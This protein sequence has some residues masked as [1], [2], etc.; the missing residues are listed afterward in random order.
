M[1][2]QTTTQTTIE[3]Q[4]H[5]ASSIHYAIARAPE[6]VRPRLQ[7]LYALHR[8]WREA[9][10]AADNHF[11]VTT[12]NWWHE[13]LQSHRAPSSSPS[14]HPALLVMQ[15]ILAQADCADALEQLLHGHM[16]WH[17][18]NRVDS[19]E[20]LL[21]TI[22]AIGGQFVRTWLALSEVQVAPDYATHAGRALWWIDQ[23]RH[24]GHQ[25]KNERIW[26]PMQWLKHTD[27]PAHLLL[28]RQQTPQQRVQQL[29][30]LIQHIHEHTLSEVAQYRAAHAQLSADERKQVRSLHLLMQLRVDLIQE[31][32][33]E[34][35][36]LFQG[37]VSLAPLR[38]WWRAVRS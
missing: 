22:D 15:P 12:L 14:G 27:V 7:A 1:M 24:L 4:A 33:S 8:K 28:N 32:M 30:K 19:L 36:A 26:I 38:K 37:L 2:N 20:Q 25:V 31:M 10:N 18:L 34:P 13:E 23:L 35:A 21:P 5:P 3:P 9:A 6:Q 16:H 11:A 29:G 17:H